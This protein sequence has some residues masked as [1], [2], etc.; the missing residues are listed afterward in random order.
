MRVLFDHGTPDRIA[1]ALYGHEVTFVRHLGWHEIANGDL[2]RQA[3]EAGFEVLLSTDKNIRYQQNLAFR[4][5]GIV[6]LGISRWPSVRRYL[7]QIAAA[8]DAAAPGTYAEVDIPYDPE[9]Q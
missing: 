2:I 1:Q 6:I 4:K 8:V 3:E 9:H 5:I 7:A